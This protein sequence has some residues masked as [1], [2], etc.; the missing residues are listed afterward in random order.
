[1]RLRKAAFS[2]TSNKFQNR[3]VPVWLHLKNK[4]PFAFAGLWDAWRDID[5]GDVL[6]T[7]TIVATYP[8]RAGA[9]NPQPNAVIYDR[10]MGRQ[11]LE[12]QVSA[13]GLD[14]ALRPRP[15]VVHVSR[16][17][18]FTFALLSAVRTRLLVE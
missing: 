13:M 3:K 6:N 16:I 17:R 10:A 11:W 15:V 4:E 7:F 1:M 18:V 12:H 2:Q 8:E 5:S 9:A 14:S